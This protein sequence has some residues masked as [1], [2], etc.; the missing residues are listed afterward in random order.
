MLGLI[1]FG[2]KYIDMKRQKFE[3]NWWDPRDLN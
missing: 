1:K 2:L 3:E